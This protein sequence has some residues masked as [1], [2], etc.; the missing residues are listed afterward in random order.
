MFISLSKQN[1]E[2]VGCFLVDTVFRQEHEKHRE[3]LPHI[4]PL[5][6]VIPL[7]LF[8]ERIGFPADNISS[9]VAWTFR[10]GAKVHAKTRRD[11]TGVRELDECETRVYPLLMQNSFLRVSF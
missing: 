9:R 5:P 1:K 7:K 3:L 2:N 6:I 8:L 10:G 4:G 11:P